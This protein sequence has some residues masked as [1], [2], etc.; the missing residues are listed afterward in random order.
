MDQNA[1]EP[2]LLKEEVALSL[3]TK[4]AITIGILLP[5]VCLSYMCCIGAFVVVREYCHRHDK[6]STYNSRFVNNNSLVLN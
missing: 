1:F 4:I 3:S 2:N 6:D 5:F